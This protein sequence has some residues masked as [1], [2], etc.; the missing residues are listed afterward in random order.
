VA[1]LVLPER[2]LLALAFVTACGARS[3]VLEPFDPAMPSGALT[4]DACL[5]EGASED[6]LDLAAACADHASCADA[7]AC[8]EACPVRLDQTCVN[9]CL[10]EGDLEGLAMVV[11]Y[12]TCVAGPDCASCAAVCGPA[13]SWLCA[14]GSASTYPLERAAR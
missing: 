9:E 2:A 8:E 3:G 12:W 6:C 14:E 5:A 1:L 10:P 4:C 13:S 11:R 7:L